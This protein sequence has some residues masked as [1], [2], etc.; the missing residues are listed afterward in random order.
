MEP[1]VRFLITLG[2]LP[3]WLRAFLA[4]IVQYILRDPVS[5]STF[6]LVGNKSAAQVNTWNIRR[7]DFRQQ[8][9]DWFQQQQLD[10]I[11][12]P[13]STIP[14]AKINGTT[15]ISAL[16]ASTLLYNVLDYPVGAIPVTKVKSGEVMDESRWKGREKEGYSWIL[17]DRVYGRGGVYKK[18]MEDGVGLP[19]GVQVILSFYL[20]LICRWLVVGML[21]RK[22]FLRLWN[23]WCLHLKQQGQNCSTSIILFP[24]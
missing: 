16:A 19:V 7:N 21:V 17:L 4:F 1:T 9:N 10:A 8:F 23:V 11:I 18:I 15:M 2:R 5:S 12:A 6:H 24:F 3:K 20:L 14:A 22:S 13:I